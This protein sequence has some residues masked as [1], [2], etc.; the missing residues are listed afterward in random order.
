MWL[1][2][3]LHCTTPKGEH[4]SYKQRKAS[5]GGELDID[6]NAKKNKS[7][8]AP[9]EN[10]FFPEPEAGHYKFW[11]EAV[12]MDRCSDPTPYHVHLSH[13]EHG[14]EKSFQDI[15]EDDEMTVFELCVTAD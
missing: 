10:I 6:M 14:E 13:G 2:V 3:D 8:D 12:D 11:V 15:Q 5:C 9:V 4:I 7:V 1:A